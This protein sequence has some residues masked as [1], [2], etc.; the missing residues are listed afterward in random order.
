MIVFLLEF[1]LKVGVPDGINPFKIIL[2]SFESVFN[3]LFPLEDVAK[4]FM[5][6]VDGI[7]F[8]IIQGRNDVMGAWLP[9]IFYQAL[10]FTMIDPSCLKAKRPLTSR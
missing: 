4:D 5:I 1:F 6:E 9:R 2:N 7:L 3:M 8:D 10:V